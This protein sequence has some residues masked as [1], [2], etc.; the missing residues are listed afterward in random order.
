MSRDAIQPTRFLPQKTGKLSPRISMKSHD[1]PRCHKILLLAVVFFIL[2][3]CRTLIYSVFCGHVM[4]PRQSSIPLSTPLLTGHSGRRLFE[5][6]S[7]STC[8]QCVSPQDIRSEFP[9]AIPSHL[10]NSCR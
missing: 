10:A 1:Q 5:I 6:R 8:G 7:L 9:K 2:K 3:E 4:D